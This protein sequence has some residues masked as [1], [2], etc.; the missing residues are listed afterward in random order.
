VIEQLQD[1]LA[2][3]TARRAQLEAELDG[4]AVQEQR[5]KDALIALRVKPARSPA[6]PGG[7]TNA[8]TPSVKTQDDVYAALARLP[9]P[10]STTQIAELIG[11]SRGTVEKALQ[12]LRKKERVRFVGQGGRGNANLYAVM[13]SD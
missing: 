10:S 9:E 6:K 8:W 1:S 12:E 7:K 2:P 13:P 5:I 11:V 3:L 4:V